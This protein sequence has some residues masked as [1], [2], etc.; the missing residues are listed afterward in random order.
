[1]TLKIF[2]Q[3][4]A[5]TWYRTLMYFTGHFT[6]VVWQSTQELGGRAVR[7]PMF[8]YI[9]LLISLIYSRTFYP[10]WKS[11]Q[12]LGVGVG[13]SGRLHVY[14][15]MAAHFTYLFQDILPRLYGS[16]PK[17]LEWDER[18]IPAARSSWWAVT[19]P[20]ATWWE[21]TPK[22]SSLLNRSKS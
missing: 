4:Y 10:V 11:S 12:E 19:D 21:I 9:W 1:M 2:I 3:K 14:L 13:A 20:R 17:S 22:T 18:E 8:T 15:Y 5:L 7:D 16:R 6:Q